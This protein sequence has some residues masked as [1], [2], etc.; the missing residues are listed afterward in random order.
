M[1]KKRVF[2]A[3]DF[4]D[5]SVKSDLLAQSKLPECPFDLIDCSIDKPIDKNW[6]VEAERRIRACECV[7]V[8][9]GEQTHQAGGASTEVQIAQALSKR[10]VCLAATRQATP[11][12]PKNIP[13]GT[14]IFTWRWATVTTLLEGSS[15]PENAIVRRAP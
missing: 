4:D 8:L 15:P 11:T 10:I 5:M 9:C 13:K 7:I 12:P 1:S 3:F 6:P 2:V 14:P